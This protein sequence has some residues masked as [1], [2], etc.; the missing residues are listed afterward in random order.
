MSIDFINVGHPELDS[1]FHVTEGD[2]AK[3]GMTDYWLG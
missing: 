1:G 3:A 2:W